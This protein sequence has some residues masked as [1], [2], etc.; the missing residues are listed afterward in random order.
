MLTLIICAF[1]YVGLSD[2]I[3]S[4]RSKKEKKI[5]IRKIRKRKEE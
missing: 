2:A 3:L 4:E 5:K 1:V